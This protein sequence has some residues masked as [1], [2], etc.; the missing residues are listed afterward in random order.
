MKHEKYEILIEDCVAGLLDNGERQLVEVHIEECARCKEYLNNARA[1]DQKL[2]SEFADDRP[3]ADLAEKVI[4]YIDEKEGAPARKILKPI[5]F[6]VSR[7]LRLAL[8]AAVV[9]L[10]FFLS[11]M[12]VE[13][14]GGSRTDVGTNANAKPSSKTGESVYLG[15]I[16][17]GFSANSKAI[18]I[19]TSGLRVQDPN[20]N[21]NYGNADSS[22]SITWA[23]MD[24][25]DFFSAQN[26]IVNSSQLSDGMNLNYAPTYATIGLLQST[27]TSMTTNI[28]STGNNTYAQ[29]NPEAM[30]K[31]YFIRPKSDNAN[32]ELPWISGSSSTG[33]RLAYDGYLHLSTLGGGTLDTPTTAPEGPQKIISNGIVE[34]EVEN[35]DETYKKVLV[36]TGEAKG[37]IASTTT[38]RLQ[39]GKM[40]G[41]VTLRVPPDQFLKVG[42]TIATLGTSKSKSLGSKD[43]TKEYIDLEARIASEKTLEERL[44]KV[45]KETKGEVK[46]ILEVE[47]QIAVV[48]QNIER[49]EGE[50]R[51][52]NNLISLATLDV[53]LYEKEI[54]KPVEY[55]QTQSAALTISVTDVDSAYKTVQETI[56]GQKGRIIE[57]NINRQNENVTAKVRAAIDAEKFPE[58]LR[59]LKEKGE[60]KNFQVEEKRTPS[61]NGAVVSFDAPIRKEQGVVDVY[62]NPVPGQYV[63]FADANIIVECDNPSPVSQ[64][65]VSLANGL[66]AIVF[67]AKVSDQEKGQKAEVKCEVPADSFDKLVEGFKSLGKVQVARV[68]RA[69][70]AYGIDPN[71]NLPPRVVKRKGIIILT[72][73]KPG[74]FIP[75]EKGVGATIKNTASTG[76]TGLLQSLGYIVVGFSYALPWIGIALVIYLVY[77]KFF[78]KPTA[79]TPK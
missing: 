22:V 48:R 70:A 63:Q 65:A 69:Q 43:V 50:Q 25:Q 36:I 23:A 52:Y 46:D 58:M 41:N 61:A 49:L 13:F 16:T 21:W 45:V 28:L 42:D 37:F 40:R 56:A 30:E 77:R 17:H 74:E 5:N 78:K 7:R 18:E 76:F 6:N 29:T 67:E 54:E 71:S 19:P 72:I 64:Q 32:Q 24:G 68:N 10:G 34:I 39:N 9:L 57:A 1:F 60:V 66:N 35:Y 75:E 31:P 3:P 20:M 14:S 51:Y 38:S 62:V 27:G 11:G 73:Q 15:S 59:T 12:L 79:P 47:K 4:A 26:A 55:V 33:W 2:N 8:G 53:S 44:Q